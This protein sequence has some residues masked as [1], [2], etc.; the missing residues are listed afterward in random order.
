MSGVL[1]AFVRTAVAFG[2]RVVAR[3]LQEAYAKAQT[4]RGGAAAPPGG[5]RAGAGGGGGGGRAGAG[6]GGAAPPPAAPEAS[7]TRMALDQARAVLALE[8]KGELTAVRVVEAFNKHHA[9]N[10][11]DTAGGSLYLQTKIWNA[12]EALLADLREQRDRKRAAE[13]ARGAPRAAA[14]STARRA[15]ATMR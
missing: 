1:L 7:G 9:L 14:A 2:M 8:E 4:A 6:A 15:G 12:K 13:A 3:G 11:P 5:S 10:D